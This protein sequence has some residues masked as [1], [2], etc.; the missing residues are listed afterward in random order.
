MSII[1][2]SSK[3]YKL[4]N[5]KIINNKIDRIA[6]TMYDCREESQESEY[7]KTEDSKIDYISYLKSY[8]PYY[9]YD[10]TNAIHT[11]LAKDYFENNVKYADAT[12]GGVGGTKIYGLVAL[13]PIY[14]DITIK[15]KPSVDSTVYYSPS[16]KISFDKKYRL[17]KKLINNFQWQT[18]ST[19][20]GESKQP[21][22]IVVQKAEFVEEVDEAPTEQ[23]I[24]RYDANFSISVWA[25]GDDTELSLS[26]DEETH[27]YTGTARAYM[28]CVC[29]TYGD[30]DD[31]LYEYRPNDTIGVSILGTEYKLKLEKETVTVSADNADFSGTEF[32]VSGNYFLQGNDYLN[33]VNQFKKTLEIYKNGLETATVLCSI[34]DYYDENGNKAIS[35]SSPDKM[36]FNLYDEVIPLYRTP[37]GDAPMSMADGK[38]KTFKVLGSKIYFDGAVWQELSLQ[39]SGLSDYV[40]QDGTQG[41]AYELM[42]NGATLSCVGIG[43]SQDYRIKIASIINGVRVVNIGN[44]A[45]ASEYIL[46]VEIPDGIITIGDYA[47]YYCVDLDSVT[48]GNNV[49]T[50]GRNAFEFCTFISSVTIGNNVKSI[51]SSAFSDC[52]NLTSIVI[53]DSVTSIGSSAFSSCENLTI[54]CEAES[55]PEGWD[56]DWNY[57]NCPV[58]WGYKGA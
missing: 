55:K 34:S 32:T 13:K 15:F 7:L 17:Y 14:R 16:V 12:A 8:E 41:L 56:S 18:I 24:N 30:G 21:W 23:S 51:G 47:F 39:E 19:P 58:I 49:E 48:I 4:S 54:Y 3:T 1:I 40:L 33:I 25:D 20:F 29:M 31:Y 22:Y 50:I 45:F 52:Y 53:P 2:P 6:V 36:S 42:P 28:G 10:E 9:W 38:P 27:T 46:S 11:N 43:D 26:Y 37:Y 57:S 5:P 35:I 44:R